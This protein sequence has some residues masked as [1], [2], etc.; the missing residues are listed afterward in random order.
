MNC[1]L[2]GINQSFT[3]QILFFDVIKYKLLYIIIKYIY[4]RN[5]FLPFILDFSAVLE[6][7]LL[8]NSEKPSKQSLLFKCSVWFMLDTGE[9]NSKCSRSWILTS[10]K[11]LSFLLTVLSHL[12]FC[13]KI[14]VQNYEI[15]LL[16]YYLYFNKFN[17]KDHK[18]ALLLGT[19]QAGIHKNLCL[20]DAKTPL[21]YRNGNVSIIQL[22]TDTVNKYLSL[23]E[24]WGIGFHFRLWF[25][26]HVHFKAMKIRFCT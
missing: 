16:L 13:N 2:F 15:V 20:V 4:R 17:R 9:L 8:V 22:L 5:V 10:I 11:T 18:S 21:V 6:Y 24:P 19:P 26:L 3:C 14:L 1:Q 23:L 12:H 7:N 25:I